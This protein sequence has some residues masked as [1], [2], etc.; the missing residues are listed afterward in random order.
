MSLS[1]SY[2]PNVPFLPIRGHCVHKAEVK[3]QNH[4]ENTTMSARPRLL[5]LD[6][7]SKTVEDAR[8]RTASGGMITLVCIF[9]VLML[10]KN[11]YNDY[12]SVIVRPEL[13]VNR[14]V[15]KQ[16]DIN[17]DVTFPD[18]PCGVLTL[19]ILDLTGDLHLDVVQSGFEMFRVVGDNEI[20]D[21]LPILSRV[22]EIEEVCK[23]LTKEEA[24]QGKPCGSCYGALNQDN[25]QYC[26]NS[27]EAVRLAYAVKEWGFFDGEK[28]EQCEQEGYVAKLTERIKNNEGCRIK[29]SAKISRISGNLH[30]APGI[31]LS[32]RGRH[33]HDVSLW[34][35]YPDKFSISHVINHFSFGSDPGS[36]LPLASSQ[37]EESAPSIHP[38]DGHRFDQRFKNHVASY[39]LSV[40]STRFEFLEGVKDPVETNQFSVIT[41]DRPIVGGRDDDHQN[42]LHA[43]GGFP[44]LVFNFDIS[45]MKIINREEYAKTWSGFILGVVSSIA[46]VLTVG[47]VLDRSVW[48]AEQVLRGKKNM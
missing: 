1:I 23:G 20:K 47:A 26:C 39:Y 43:Q 32:R 4:L 22:N 3:D 11:E 16:L 41:H 46:G 28:I 2:S 35:K 21:D 5:S 7:F 42:T 19:D 10:I 30:F 29:G 38:L 18:V 25:N 40:V 33:L 14:D 12:T 45:P 24:E 36:S 44:G 17:L 15:N 37:S 27:C 8:V 48:A 9:I 31:P 34:G 6:A 13:V